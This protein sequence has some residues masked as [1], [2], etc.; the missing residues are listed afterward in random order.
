MLLIMI[1]IFIMIKLIIMIKTV[2]LINWEREGESNSLLA[3]EVCIMRAKMGSG[4]IEVTVRTLLIDT[5]TSGVVT[6]YNQVI[7]DVLNVQK[8]LIVLSIFIDSFY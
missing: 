5:Y 8:V 3:Q 6:Y 1:T 2:Q 4:F 7:I